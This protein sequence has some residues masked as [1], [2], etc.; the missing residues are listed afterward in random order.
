M[1]YR[2]DAMSTTLSAAAAGQPAGLP[3]AKRPPLKP[4]DVALAE[5]LAAAVPLPGVE[6]VS[7][8]DADGR[9]LA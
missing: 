3:A 8:F 7:T 1:S 5:L 9:V 6:T 2:I 4:L